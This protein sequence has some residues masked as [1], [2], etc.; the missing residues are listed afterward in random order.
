MRALLHVFHHGN[1][2][3]MAPFSRIVL[4]FVPVLEWYVILAVD[5]HGRDVS[6]LLGMF[7]CVPARA[8]CDLVGC[9]GW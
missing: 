3:S 5:C 2:V 1:N 8:H 6:E 7:V 9:Y 4:C